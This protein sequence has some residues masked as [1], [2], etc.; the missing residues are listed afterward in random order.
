MNGVILLSFCSQLCWRMKSLRSC[1]RNHYVVKT[2]GDRFNRSF[3]TVFITETSWPPDR[4]TEL[5]SNC[6]S[7]VETQGKLSGGLTVDWC[8]WS[9]SLCVS[10]DEFWFSDG[11]LADRSKFSDP[12]LMPLP[13]TATGLDW[14]HLVD[15]ARA[16]EGGC[17]SSITFRPE[18]KICVFEL[19]I[20][21]PW[22]WMT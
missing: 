22:I 12:G 6:V 18:C 11:S 7:A 21:F 20:K 2:A 19:R 17:R 15:A 4:W 9:V 3:S 14:S 16:F 8:H 5:S 10:S 13:D 1:K